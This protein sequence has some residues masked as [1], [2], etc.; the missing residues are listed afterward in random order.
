MELMKRIVVLLL[1]FFITL[2]SQALPDSWSQSYCTYDI[3]EVNAPGYYSFGFAVD[4]FA[5]YSNDPDTVAYDERRFDLFAKLGIFRWLEV[6]LKYSS[7][8]AGL[9]AGK[10]QFL[11]GTVNAAF[12]LGFGYMKGTRIG[13]I[14]DYVFDFYPTL[15][16]STKLYKEIGLYLAPKCIYSIHPRDTREHSNREPRHIFQYGYGIGL[17]IGN[18]FRIMP[19]ANWVFG[20]NRGLKYTVNQFGIG[21][22]LKI[23]SS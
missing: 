13:Y 22:T 23:G 7:P 15:I 19:E 20:N 10:Y 21:V 9:V 16:V 1:L 18:S 4:N 14:T 5:L 2:F 11:S 8:T 12:K 17:I 6:E 3:A